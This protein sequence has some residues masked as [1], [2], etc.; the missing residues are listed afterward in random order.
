MLFVPG[1]TTHGSLHWRT[2]SHIR[3]RSEP[4]RRAAEPR[5]ELVVMAVAAVA[6]AAVVVVVLA[7]A[8]GFVG[9]VIWLVAVIR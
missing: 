7:T 4:A 1:P 8:V 5:S 9:A 6:V 3:R 2:R